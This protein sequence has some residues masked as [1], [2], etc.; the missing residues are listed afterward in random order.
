MVEGEMKEVSEDVML[1]ALKV[2]HQSIKTHCRAIKELEQMAYYDPLT[3]LRSVYYFF[4]D[5]H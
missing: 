4:S 1:E 5:H 3:D 2:A